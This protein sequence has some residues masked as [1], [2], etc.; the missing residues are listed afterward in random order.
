MTLEEF[1]A[2]QVETFRYTKPQ[3]FYTHH[4]TI[5]TIEGYTVQKQYSYP[6]IIDR[7]KYYVTFVCSE[8]GSELL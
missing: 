3:T 4:Q 7:I 5:K 6:N 1:E 2:Y 8:N